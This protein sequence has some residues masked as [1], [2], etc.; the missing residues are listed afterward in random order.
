MHVLLYHV[1]GDEMRGADSC[2]GWLAGQQAGMNK[3][4]R[5]DGRSGL[6]LLLLVGA[7]GILSRDE[8]ME[9]W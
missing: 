4:R 1:R 6:K 9:Q 7:V 8:P 3:M 2:C 5:T